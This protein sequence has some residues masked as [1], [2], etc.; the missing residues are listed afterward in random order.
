VRV[1]GVAGLQ[2]DPERE[3]F[4]SAFPDL[5]GEVG[6]EAVRHEVVR[7]GANELTEFLLGFHLRALF[8]H[9]EPSS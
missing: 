5:S 6:F 3:Q 7:C 8:H 4:E 2:E 9:D 1:T